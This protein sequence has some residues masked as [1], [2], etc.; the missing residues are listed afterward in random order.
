MKPN[1]KNQGSARKSNPPNLAA[2]SGKKFVKNQVMN[3]SQIGYNG[4]KSFVDNP[5]SFLDQ[6]S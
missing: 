1:Y 2:N 5:S 4:P 3:H 6:K